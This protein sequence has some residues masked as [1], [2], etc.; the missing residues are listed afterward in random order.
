MVLNLVSSNDPILYEKIKR[1]DFDN[2]LINPNQLAVDLTETMLSKNGIGLAANQV[3]LRHRAFVIRSNPVIA[4]FNPI[5]VDESSE[6][7]NDYEGCLTF[8][9]ML[10]KIKRPKTIKVRYTQPNGETLTKIFQG[11]TARIF[12]HE[13]DHLEG[14]VFTKRASPTRLAMAKNKMKVKI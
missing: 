5:V 13:L 10:I 7:W 14:I 9:G 6:T 3:G 2:P 4:C 8:P 1:F 12:L 11:I